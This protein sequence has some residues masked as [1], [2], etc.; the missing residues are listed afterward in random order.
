M[1]ML[2]LVITNTSATTAII[3][4]VSAGNNYY[5]KIYPLQLGRTITQKL[6]IILTTGAIPSTNS[7]TI[8]TPTVYNFS[9]Y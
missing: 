5:F 9:E 2:L 7:T 4:S 6:T 3:T 1:D 8:V